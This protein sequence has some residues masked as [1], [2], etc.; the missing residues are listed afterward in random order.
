MWGADAW[1]SVPWATLG[2]I[3]TGAP[4]VVPGVV[5]VVAHLSGV[6][7]RFVIVGVTDGLTLSGASEAYALPTIQ[8][9]Q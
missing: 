9:V 1:G 2:V 6:P 8:G 5:P 4:P 3:V 7:E